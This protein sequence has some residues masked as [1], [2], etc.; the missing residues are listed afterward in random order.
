MDPFKTPFTLTDAGYTVPGALTLSPVAAAVVTTTYLCTGPQMAR[1]LWPLYLDNTN[2]PVLQD[3]SGAFLNYVEV[4]DG[5]GNPVH[6]WDTDKKSSYILHMPMNAMK[7]VVDA[8]LVKHVRVALLSNLL[9]IPAVYAGSGIE[10]CVSYNAGIYGICPKPKLDLKNSI[11]KLN[12]T[13][14]AY[15]EKDVET[16][17]QPEKDVYVVEKGDKKI[18][19]TVTIA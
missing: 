14:Q 8:S 19:V 7:R 13:N 5:F 3:A 9:P 12:N 16:T 6:F 11:V 4:V 2:T 17:N 1:C 18:T 10:M 15:V